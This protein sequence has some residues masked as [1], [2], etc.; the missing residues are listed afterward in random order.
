MAKRIAP[1][2]YEV[3]DQFGRTFEVDGQNGID[4]GRNEW[5][6]F[7]ISPEGDRNWWE[8]YPT[9]RD[10]IEDIKSYAKWS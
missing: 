10:A 1:S 6:V 9:K 7:E 4:N 2:I 3:Q 8:T 5:Q